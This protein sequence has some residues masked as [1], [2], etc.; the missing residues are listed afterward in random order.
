MRSREL[1]FF[2]IR[3]YAEN[4]D[5]M[6]IVYHS[7]YLCFFE[8]ARTEMIRES[9]LSLSARATYDYH[10]TITE[11]DLRYLYPAYVDD[12][13]KVTTNIASKK[14]CSLVFDQC[15][16]NQHNTLLCKARIKVACIDNKMKPRR[17]PVDLF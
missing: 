3:V 5:M 12:L 10:F 4:T 13:L 8:R 7:N 17:L 16:H 15:I 14:S 2:D 11:S 9:G 1:H 6:G